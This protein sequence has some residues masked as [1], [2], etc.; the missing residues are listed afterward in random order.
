MIIAFLLLLL[1]RHGNLVI[2]G[3]DLTT[4]S[5]LEIFEGAFSSSDSS[6][7]ESYSIIFIENMVVGFYF[8]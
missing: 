2:V 3:I 1:L 5:D 6:S 8:L 4:G 7:S